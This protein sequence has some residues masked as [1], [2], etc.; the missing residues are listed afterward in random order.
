MSVHIDVL[1]ICFISVPTISNKSAKIRTHRSVALLRALFCWQGAG[2]IK[3]CR[4]CKPVRHSW[5]TRP[6]FLPWLSFWVKTC[7]SKGT[8]LIVIFDVQHLQVT[9]TELHS[10]LLAWHSLVCLVTSAEPL[11][12]KVRYDWLGSFR[13][14]A[15][16][17]AFCLVMAKTC[18]GIVGSCCDACRYIC[19]YHWTVVDNSES[20]YLSIFF[21]SVTGARC[22]WWHRF[23]Q[24]NR[25][26]G[27]QA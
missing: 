9:R 2:G 21:G 13:P 6:S 16:W 19:V 5:N 11:H 10:K 20:G 18:F 26:R 17:L 15:V 4:V 8:D 12:R 1:D 27:Q 3:I 22:L 24:N 7:F 14:E 23:H 25:A